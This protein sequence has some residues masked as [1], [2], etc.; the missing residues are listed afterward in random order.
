[1]GTG[2][3]E[4]LARRKLIGRSSPEHDVGYFVAKAFYTKALVKVS[5]K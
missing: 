4:W 2:R 3:Q 5:D 1:M